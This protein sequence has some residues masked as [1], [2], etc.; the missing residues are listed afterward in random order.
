ISKTLGLVTFGVRAIE[1]QTRPI[2]PVLGEINGALE[3]VAGALETVAGVKSP[4][5]SD[6]EPEAPMEPMTG[7][8]AQTS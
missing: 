7:P 4:P 2:G 3:Q 8:K 6:P 1:M 5:A